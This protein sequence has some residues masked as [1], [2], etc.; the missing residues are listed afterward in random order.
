MFSLFK[1]KYPYSHQIHMRVVRFAMTYGLTRYHNRIL[2]ENLVSKHILQ[3]NFRLFL[4]IICQNEFKAKMAKNGKKMEFGSF[5]S[6][7]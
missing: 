2:C 6:Q 4:F 3:L 1:S 7:E 5:N